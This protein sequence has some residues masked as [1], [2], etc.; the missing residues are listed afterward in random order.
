MEY[1][2]YKL[3]ER[4]D[5]HKAT[6]E[7][8]LSREGKTKLQIAL[9]KMDKAKIKKT[10]KYLKEMEYE[11][12][13]GLKHKEWEN[14]DKHLTAKNYNKLSDKLRDDFRMAIWCRFCREFAEKYLY[15]LEKQKQV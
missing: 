5:F 4:I 14:I 10:I 13:D 12:L 11:S 6:R 15:S 8:P 2:P 3:P 9:S 7:F 1:N